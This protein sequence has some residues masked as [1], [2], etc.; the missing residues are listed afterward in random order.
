M[1]PDDEPTVQPPAPSEI[2][3][4]DIEN[5]KTVKKKTTTFDTSN[6]NPPSEENT[7]STKDDKIK[8]KRPETEIITLKDPELPP[9]A[10]NTMTQRTIEIA[11]AAVIVNNRITTPVT[12]QLRPS[13]GSTNL[14]VLKAHKNIFSAMKLIDP[15][16]K[17]IT[18][19]NETIDTTDQFPSSAI[20]YTSKF[21]NFYKDPKTSRVYISHKIESAIPLGEIKYGNRQQLSNIFDTLVTNNAYLNL[22]K[23]CTHKEHSIGFFTHINPKVTLRDNFRNEIQNELMWI[24]LDDEESAPLIH[25]VKDNKGNPTGQQ[26]IILPAFDLYSKEVGD[27]NGNERV[28][29]F[30]YEIRT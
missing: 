1:I 4:D 27:G 9:N 26:K 6:N 13:K 10:N 21:T 11:T 20:E 8:E 14:N 23:F 3:D 5:K 17:L 29:T 19:Q 22:N 16:L 15:T 24:D 7:N 12:L 28:T 30:A 18:F 2:F 25:Q